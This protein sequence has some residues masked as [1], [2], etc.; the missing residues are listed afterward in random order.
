MAI[1]MTTNRVMRLHT[2][3]LHG[4]SGFGNRSKGCSVW[5]ETNA[6]N[7]AAVAQ[8]SRTDSHTCTHTHRETDTHT[9]TLCESSNEQL[10][11]RTH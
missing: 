8:P 10:W 6:Y 9:H 7:P 1:K 3:R 11:K 5:P 2:I 4:L